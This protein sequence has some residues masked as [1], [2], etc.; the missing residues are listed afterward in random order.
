[1]LKGREAL[2]AIMGNML[3]TPDD[4]STSISVLAATYGEVRDRVAIQGF[5]QNNPNYVAP[6]KGIEYFVENIQ[7]KYQ[8][9]S[10]DYIISGCF[11]HIQQQQGYFVVSHPDLE[12][13]YVFLYR[14]HSMNMIVIHPFQVIDGK[15]NLTTPTKV[16]AVDGEID[17]EVLERFT[18]TPDGEG[19]QYSF[20]DAK[21]IENMNYAKHN[22]LLFCFISNQFYAKVAE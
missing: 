11:S 21:D 1:M 10:G 20:Y 19:D 3:E 13:E 16:S 14:K 9:S 4:A 22:L 5:L 7:G 12:M 2:Y 6:K 17:I 15:W 8:S 18:T